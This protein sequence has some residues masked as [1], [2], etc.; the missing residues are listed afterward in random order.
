M[1]NPFGLEQTVT[2]GVV[3]AKGR[4]GFGITQYEDFIQTDASINQGNS[5]GPLLNI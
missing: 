2:I 1:G 4:H 3:S 5:G